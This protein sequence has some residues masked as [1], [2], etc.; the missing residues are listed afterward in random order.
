MQCA[1]QRRA[2]R[3]QRGAV[4]QPGDA[5]ALAGRLRGARGRRHRE[6]DAR[7][8]VRAAVELQVG[9]RLVGDRHAAEARRALRSR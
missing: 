3:V 7:A 8:E 9:G 1:V 6:V 4:D 5:G 2:A